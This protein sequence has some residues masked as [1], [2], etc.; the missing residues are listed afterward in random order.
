MLAAAFPRGDGLSS[1][2][3]HFVPFSAFNFIAG[4]EV[5]IRISM[6]DGGTAAT[7]VCV[8]MG[9]TGAAFTGGGA[10]VTGACGGGGGGFEGLL[11]SSPGGMFSW[12]GSGVDRLYP[13]TPDRADA[14]LARRLPGLGPSGAAASSNFR[15][16]SSRSA[17]GGDSVSVS[18]RDRLFPPVA[19]VSCA[20]VP[21][22]WLLRWQ[23]SW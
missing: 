8:D 2:V 20:I 1:P 3:S 21:G 6:R 4:L 7:R 5:G 12:L 16:F 23:L 10:A 11:S 15:R 17:L 22:V 19:A 18:S 9:T 14:I 13:K